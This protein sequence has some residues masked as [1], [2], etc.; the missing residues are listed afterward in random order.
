MKIASEPIDDQTGI[1]ERRIQERRRDPDQHRRV[2]RAIALR[3]AFGSDTA[4]RLLRGA[5]ID[6]E[7]AREIWASGVDRRQLRRRFPS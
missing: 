6:L 4:G 3:R 2:T 1:P 7:W 5:N